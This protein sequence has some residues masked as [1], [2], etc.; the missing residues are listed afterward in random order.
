MKRLL[1]SSAFFNSRNEPLWNGC[2]WR[3]AAF[4]VW[5]LDLPLINPTHEWIEV[6]DP[7][8]SIVC[9]RLQPRRIIGRRLTLSASHRAIATGRNCS[10]R[11]KARTV[12]FHLILRWLLI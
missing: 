4:E 3:K 5:M 11:G 7:D 10:L 12:P 8:A 1:L 6:G 2:L 9:H